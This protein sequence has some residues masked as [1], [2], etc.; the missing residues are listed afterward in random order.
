MS[1]IQPINVLDK[2]ELA[3]M[4]TNEMTMNSYVSY[5]N[6]VNYDSFSPSFQGSR[7]G[8]AKKMSKAAEGKGDGFFANTGH[9][10]RTKAML[11]VMSL[12]TLLG[13]V[14]CNK[15]LVDINIVIN[16][17][18]SALYD[19][20][21][22]QM[23][24]NNQ[25]HEDMLELQRL[26][27]EVLLRLIANGETLE[28]IDQHVVENGYHLEDLVAG[29]E[30]LVGLVRIL[31]EKMG[32]LEELGEGGNALGLQIL[33][34]ILTMNS[35]Q[36]A[37]YDALIAWLNDVLMNKLDDMSE[38]EAA[39]HAA[40]INAMMQMGEELQGTLLQILA[41]INTMDQ[42]MQQG[43]FALLA[44]MQA[45][46]QQLSAQL[47]ELLSHMDEWGEE[48]L[49]KFN[50]LI[51]SFNNLSQQVQA[52]I[53]AIL[54][55]LDAVLQNQE[56][57]QQQVLNILNKL[58]Q[59]GANLETLLENFNDYGA[60]VQAGIIQILAK[61]DGMS[62]QLQQLITG[63]LNIIGNQQTII[64]L[65]QQMQA[66]AL[67]AYAEIIAH[68][69]TIEQ[70]QQS[71]AEWLARIFVQLQN[72]GIQLSEI[73]RFL[74]NVNFGPDVNLDV[75]IA[76]LQQIIAQ[77]EQHHNEL[78]QNNNQNTQLI[79]NSINLIRAQL[80]AMQNDFNT[81]FSPAHFDYLERILNAIM[82]IDIETCNCD[83][84]LIIELLEQIASDIHDGINHEGYEEEDPYSELGLEP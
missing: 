11:L 5:L 29:Q 27:R 60:Q 70:N 78:L 43:Y 25:N 3:K 48:F 57:Q 34:A 33:Q 55:R 65:M 81:N 52:G 69:G 71:N 47:V 46:G 61:L 30:E 23:E 21:A 15:P 13:V 6:N 2:Q 42:H 41:K 63:A 45:I 82:G 84:E 4:N 9:K 20:L 28:E 32:H 49:A 35:D 74:Q 19:L 26:M 53:A 75:V 64:N 58:N 24:Q 31:V 1:S 10:L 67:A 68:M 36:N 80:T 40:I 59:I 50:Q 8:L 76:L 22:Q 62:L 39:Q 17:D 66:E 54:A 44:Q 72:N 83:C 14:A 79:V 77:N 7:D 12:M 16:Q 51:N 73:N 56:E 38:Q 37:N 18:Y